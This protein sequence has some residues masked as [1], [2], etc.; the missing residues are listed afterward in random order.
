VP[1]KLALLFDA[2]RFS[3][4][5]LGGTFSSIEASSSSSAKDVDDVTDEDD[6][7]GDFEDA[8]KDDETDERP[9]RSLNNAAMVAIPG[10]ILKIVARRTDASKVQRFSMIVIIYLE[11]ADHMLKFRILFRFGFRSIILGICR[12][13]A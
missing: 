8:F 7:D 10:A 12:F 1:L 13:S 4:A 11:T 5:D 9:R 6:V 2:R 3:V